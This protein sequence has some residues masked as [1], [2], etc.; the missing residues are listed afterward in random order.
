MLSK[1]FP[2]H[3]FPKCHVFLSP[4]VKKN[5]FVRNELYIGGYTQSS[6]PVCHLEL[7]GNREMS[8]RFN[9]P[10]SAR[11][12]AWLLYRLS[13]SFLALPCRDAVLLSAAQ[14]P[15]QCFDKVNSGQGPYSYIRKGN[16]ISTTVFGCPKDA[17]HVSA[18]AQTP[19]PITC[20]TACCRYNVPGR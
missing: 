16:A 14:K 17:C 6:V 20:V 3:D 1:P 9:S 2:C 11:S 12:L 10:R 18:S 13:L 19:I 5:S 15:R 7:G 4:F 8:A